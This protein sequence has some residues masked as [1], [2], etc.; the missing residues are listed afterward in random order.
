MTIIQ[1]CRLQAGETFEILA[2]FFW[3][4]I[5]LLGPLS[6]ALASSYIVSHIFK[7]P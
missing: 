1:A 2:I 7:T 3:T 4:C 5:L 6:G